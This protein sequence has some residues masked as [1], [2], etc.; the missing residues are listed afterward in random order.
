MRRIVILGATSGIGLE[1]AR[2]FIRQ[3]WL[4]GAA[5]RREEALEALR[6]EA[7]EQVVTAR[8]DVTEPE[9]AE[10]LRELVARTG[11]M[12]IYLHCSGIGY[13]NPQLDAERELATLRTN[14][15]GFVRCVRTAYELLAANGGGRLA[16]VTSV[17]GTRGLGTAPAYSA[18]KRLQNTYLDALAQHAHL[19]GSAVRITDIRPGFVATEL[20][21]D[22]RYPMLMR[23]ETVARRIVRALLRGRRSV[24]IDARYALLVALWRLLPHP[25]WER[26]PIRRRGGER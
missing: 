9:A 12:E 17:A 11:G 2:L 3:G 20:L 15:E 10:R 14:G 26:L 5:G 21:K 6:R 24:V 19:T 1:V 7:P 8:I 16:A 25:L 22:G 23:P 4:V 18:T 13:Y